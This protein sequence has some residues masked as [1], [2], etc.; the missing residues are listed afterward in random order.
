MWLYFYDYSNQ[1]SHLDACFMTKNRL[2]S[3]NIWYFYIYRLNISNLVAQP[4]INTYFPLLSC[5]IIS[6]SCHYI[7]MILA[8]KMHTCMYFLWIKL[9]YNLR[10]YGFLY[11]QTGYC[12]SGCTNPILILTFPCCHVISFIYIY[13]YSRIPYKMTEL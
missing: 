10:R 7:C 1:N 3:M 9:N 5:Y 13:V 11:I 8:L 2:L 12:S 6:L 4:H